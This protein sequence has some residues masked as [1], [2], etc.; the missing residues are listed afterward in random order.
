ME[1]FLNA[2][3]ANPFIADDLEKMQALYSFLSAEL[4]TVLRLG[5]YLKDANLFIPSGER[6]TQLN[7][8]LP[9]ASGAP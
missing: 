2:F 5:L 4:E 3:Q 6:Y 7:P 1:R 9:A 8:A